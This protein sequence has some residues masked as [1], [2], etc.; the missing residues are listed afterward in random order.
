VEVTGL[1]HLSVLDSGTTE[2]CRERDGLQ[3]PISDPYWRSG[4]VPSL[5]WRCRSV[6]EPLF[7]DFEPSQWRPVTQPM[8]GFGMNPVPFIRAVQVA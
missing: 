5:H 8:P 3:L 7:H 2:I 1:R 6:L 4:G